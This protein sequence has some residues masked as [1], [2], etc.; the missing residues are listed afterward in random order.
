VVE[1]AVVDVPDATEGEVP[2]AFVV[3]QSDAKANAREL[4]KFC[5]DKLA[6]FKIPTAIEFKSLLPRTN[7]GKIQKF[8]LCEK[9]WA[10][11]EKRI[12]GV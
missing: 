6:S 12:R 5:R 11:H 7:S 9:E 2:N 8:L 4:I 3:L 1:A 10:G